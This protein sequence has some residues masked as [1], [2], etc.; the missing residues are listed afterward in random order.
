MMPVDWPRRLKMSLMTIVARLSEPCKNITSEDQAF[1]RNNWVRLKPE[2]SKAK[3]ALLDELAVVKAVAV[4][5]N[6]K[7]KEADKE[8]SKDFLKL[9]DEERFIDTLVGFTGNLCRYV[10]NHPNE[11]I[12]HNKHHIVSQL[13]DEIN[14]V[15]EQREASPIERLEYLLKR[16]EILNLQKES[17][18]ELTIINKLREKLDSVTSSQKDFL[19]SNWIKATGDRSG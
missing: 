3:A 14:T 19:R 11:T 2:V 1:L 9:Y 15:L 4:F 17:K 5:S 12:T 7:A 16:A 6:P 13:L 18:G 10:I 8:K